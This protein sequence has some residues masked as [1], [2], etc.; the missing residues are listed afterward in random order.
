MI[1]GNTWTATADGFAGGV[2]AKKQGILPGKLLSK[3]KI[4]AIFAGVG[5]AAIIFLGAILFAVTGSYDRVLN[6]HRIV[7]PD[8][9]TISQLSAPAEKGGDVE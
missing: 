5:A 3:L 9:Y 8:N 6:K 7:G 4:I 2:P 1:F